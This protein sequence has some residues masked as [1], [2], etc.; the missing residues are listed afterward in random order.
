MRPLGN[1]LSCSG[2][3]YHI[4]AT[5]GV[6][7]QAF[8]LQDPLIGLLMLAFSF[9]SNTDTQKP[10]THVFTS[11]MVVIVHPLM[12]EWKTGVPL[13]C[14][15]TQ[16]EHLTHWSCIHTYTLELH[17]YTLIHWSCIVYTLELHT[18]W[19]CILAN[20]VSYTLVWHL[21]EVMRC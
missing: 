20:G 15:L 5:R 16:M 10:H 7:H 11:H 2:A 6:E 18:H 19:S 8:I 12:L 3:R 9:A 13:C 14:I 21:H 1:I 4:K 17:A